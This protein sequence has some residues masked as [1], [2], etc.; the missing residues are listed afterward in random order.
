MEYAFFIVGAVIRGQGCRCKLDTL[1]HGAFVTGGVCR[2]AQ[3]PAGF[4]L[5][6]LLVIKLCVTGYHRSGGHVKL[7]LLNQE[8]D[9]GGEVTGSWRLVSSSLSLVKEL[10]GRCFWV[11]H[12]H[13]SHGVAPTT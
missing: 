13:H 2:H 8:R 4:T 6:V 5:F 1:G 7:I 3:R 11:S 9:G 10:L 12:L